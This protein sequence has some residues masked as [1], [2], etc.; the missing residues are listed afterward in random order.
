MFAKIKRAIKNYYL[1]KGFHTNEKYLIIE[2]DDW[3]SIRMPSKSV[4]LKLQELGDCPEKDAFL[5]NDC[6]ESQKDLDNLFAVLNS[7]RDSCG[8]PAI[9][10]ANFAMA[11]PD[12]DNID[13]NNG[14]Y[15]YEPF[16]KTYDR[17]YGKNDILITIKNSI[18]KKLI[19]PQLHCREHLN[20]TRWMRDLKNNVPSARLAFDQK[21][22]GIGACFSCDNLFGYMD[23][24]NFDKN[25]ENLFL[26]EVLNDAS[27][28]FEKTFGFKSETFVASCFVWGNMLERHLSNLSIK[29]IQCGFW[30][31][32]PTESEGTCNLKR[33]MHYCGQK[34]KYGQV[35]LV[36][37]C[38]YEPAYLQNAE[39]SADKCFDEIRYAFKHKKP[40]IINSH[41]FN[42]I[43]SINSD[44]A[45][46]NLQGLKNLLLKVV[47]EFPD[48]K[49]ISS[50]E[51]VKIIGE[52]R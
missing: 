23:S 35:F 44:N 30:Q 20:V 14:I 27:N 40:A 47:K 28:I 38:T 37:N 16:Y 29:G 51:L 31:N 52:K 18:D 34:G 24:F 8:N 7:V 39:E 17:Y 6:L 4:F 21:M 43:S 49:F 41:R 15:K 46:Q 19:C 26:L 45:K 12:F 48:V 25:E 1:S 9:L 2:S 50:A 5:S 11:N 36:R 33:K 10:T 42:Y 32:M 3:G 22:I 13:Y